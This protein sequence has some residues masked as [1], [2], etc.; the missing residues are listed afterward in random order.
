M[1][2]GNVG[3]V[4]DSADLQS[5]PTKYFKKNPNRKKLGFFIYKKALLLPYVLTQ[6][7]S[8]LSEAWFQIG[9]V[10]QVHTVT[11]LTVRKMIMK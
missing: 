7:T 3:N 2:M 4:P 11:G 9:T 10:A 6:K 1:V 5:V 8:I